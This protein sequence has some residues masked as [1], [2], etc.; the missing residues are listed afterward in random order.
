VGRPSPIP[1]PRAIRL[2]SIPTE[3]FPLLELSES[4][5]AGKFD[6]FTGEARLVAGVLGFVL[7]VR[8]GL[9]PE[10]VL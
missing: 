10:D 4:V 5:A 2:L 3:S 8:F 7:E 9:E 1:I 6:G